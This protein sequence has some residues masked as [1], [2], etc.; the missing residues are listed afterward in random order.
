MLSISL[1][2]EEMGITVTESSIPIAKLHFVRIEK[3][4]FWRFP[5]D[6]SVDENGHH[7][8]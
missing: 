7:K 5:E 3:K 6:I 4:E 1:H 8:I 2:N